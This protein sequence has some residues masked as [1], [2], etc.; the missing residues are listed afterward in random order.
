MKSGRYEVLPRVRKLGRCLHGKPI[1]RCQWKYPGKLR[2]HRGKALRYAN[3]FTGFGTT[4]DKAIH[5][6]R[7][8]YL[9]FEVS[10]QK[11]WDNIDKMLDGGKVAIPDHLKATSNIPWWKRLFRV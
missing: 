7:M 6:C 10:R 8:Q 1:Y 3:T 4:P 9:K 5:A 11:T 2:Q